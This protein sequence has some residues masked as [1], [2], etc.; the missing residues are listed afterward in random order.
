MMLK[1]TKMIK[2]VKFETLSCLKHTS[3]AYEHEKSKEKF[4]RKSTVSFLKLIFFR[5][6]FQFTCTKNYSITTGMCIG[7]SANYW[8]QFVNIIRIRF[9]SVRFEKKKGRP[10]NNNWAFCLVNDKS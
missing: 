2:K 7:L 1:I 5:P 10:F 3:A 8:L 4:H 6:T 9:D